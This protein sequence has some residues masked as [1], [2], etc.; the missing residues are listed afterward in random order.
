MP[1]TVESRFTNNDTQASLSA[2]LTVTPDLEGSQSGTL[3]VQT[4][5]VDIDHTTQIA[6]PGYVFLWNRGTTDKLRIGLATAVYVIELR[7]GEFATLFMEET[8]VA[9]LFVIANGTN[10]S[11]GN[12]TYQILER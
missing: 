5:E 11:G 12:F 3:N 8:Q 4:T 1:F 2:R 10:E 9:R 6:K 7:P